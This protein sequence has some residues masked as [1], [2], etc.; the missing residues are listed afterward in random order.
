MAERH[1]MKLRLSYAK[2]AEFQRRGVVHLHAM[3]RLDAVDP[4]DPE[5][6]VEPP[7]GFTAGQLAQLMTTAAGRTRFTTEP[8]GAAWR[9][10]VRR[11][12]GSG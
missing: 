3:I 2:V 5:A 11:V 6:V 9:R 1:G 4:L 12:D 8:P 7:A 10:V